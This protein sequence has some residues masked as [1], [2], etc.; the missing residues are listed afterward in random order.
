MKSEIPNL[1]MQMFEFFNKN[2]IA[3]MLNNKQYNIRNK[4]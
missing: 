1:N 2:N 4:P 3:G